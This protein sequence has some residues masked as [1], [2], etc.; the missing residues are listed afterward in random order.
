MTLASS[1]STSVSIPSD[2]LDFCA[3]SLFK[4]C[5]TC[6][7]STDS[8]LSLLQTSTLVSRGHASWEHISV[9]KN[10]AKKALNTL[11]FSYSFATRSPAPFSSTPTFSIV[12]LLILMYLPFLLLFPSLDM[13]HDLAFGFPKPGPACTDSVY[14]PPGHLSLLPPLVHIFLCMSLFGTTLFTM[15][16]L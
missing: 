2:P 3:S 8:K 12:F 10:K 13:L 16:G 1:L 15:Q 6:S 11:V 4:Y 9:I 7:S 5:L 14:I